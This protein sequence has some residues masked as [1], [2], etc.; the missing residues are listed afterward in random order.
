MNSEK[1]CNELVKLTKSLYELLKFA[2]KAGFNYAASYE[3]GV[4]FVKDL[5]EFLKCEEYEGEYASIQDI[6]NNYK[7]TRQK[8]ITKE[9]SSN[10]E[11][12]KHN[13][14]EDLIKCIKDQK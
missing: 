9:C 3:Y 10:C 6:L 13:C 2:K 14:V 12:C 11:A 4:I 5:S 7:P 8:L 1:K